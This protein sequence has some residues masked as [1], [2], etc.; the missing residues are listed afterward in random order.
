M[1]ERN[2]KIHGMVP[3]I[4]IPDRSCLHV[5]NGRTA[6]PKICIHGYEC[7]HCAFDQWIEDMPEE[8]EAMESFNKERDFLARAA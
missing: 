6:I 7:R 3:G 2:V 1:R 8:Q 5:E 4:Q